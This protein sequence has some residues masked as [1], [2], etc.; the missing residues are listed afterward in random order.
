MSSSQHPPIRAKRVPRLSIDPIVSQCILGVSR[1]EKYGRN[2]EKQSKNLDGETGV[3]LA[4]DKA[5][6]T[7]AAST[8]RNLLGCARVYLSPAPCC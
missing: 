6:G 5:C 1:S 2:G 4:S 7:K 8:D 3:S